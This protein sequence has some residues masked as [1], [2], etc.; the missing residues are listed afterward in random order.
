VLETEAK[1][2]GEQPPGVATSPVAGPTAA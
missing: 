1:E 2:R